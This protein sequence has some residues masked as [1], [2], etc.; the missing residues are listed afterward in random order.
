MAAPT[1]DN[2]D[3]GEIKVELCVFNEE[4]GLG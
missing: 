4:T 2:S 1:E 3:G